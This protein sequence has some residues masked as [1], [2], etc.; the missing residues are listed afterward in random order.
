VQAEIAYSD[1]QGGG[2]I[3]GAPP[4]ILIHGAGGD[5]YH[6]PPQLRRNGPG[7][8]LSPDLPG[9]GRSRGPGEASISRYFE[10]LEAW[11]RGLDLE[12]ALWCGHS[13]GSAIAL[14]AALRAPARVAGLILIGSGARLAVAPEL[15]EGLRNMPDYEATVERILR[16]SFSRQTAPQLRALA[17]ARL[18]QTPPPVMLGDF[19]ACDRFDVRAR[20]SEISIPAL[21]ICGQEDRM[22]PPHLS[23]ELVEAMPQAEWVQIPDA[24]HMV[25]LEQPNQVQTA[26]TDFSSRLAAR[27]G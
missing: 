12:S 21:V 14:C 22:T 2:L 5:R 23:Q 13:M 9:H 27:M 11:Q 17:G 26:I 3:S 1:H 10:H 4:L 6:W 18:I 16:W 20:L 25:M 8:I 7:R 15:L 19:L 24:G